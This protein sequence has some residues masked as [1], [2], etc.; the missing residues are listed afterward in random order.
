MAKGVAPFHLIIYDGFQIQGKYRR[1]WLGD[2][3]GW[4][5]VSTVSNA[6]TSEVMGFRFRFYFFGRGGAG[7]PFQYHGL[8]FLKRE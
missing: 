5:P 7:F 3:S 6:W 8:G 4:V 1:A 2:N